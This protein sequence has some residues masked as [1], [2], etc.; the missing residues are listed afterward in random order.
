ML[1]GC[2]AMGQLG[3][4]HSLVQ[5]PRFEQADGR[6]AEIK[7]SQP[8]LSQPLGA[9]SVRVWTSVTNPNPFGFTIRRLATTLMLDGRRAATSDFPLGLSL[10][11]RQETVIPLDLVLDF[12]DIPGLAAVVRRA[13]GGQQVGYLLEGTIGIDAGAF[14]QPTFGPLTLVTG[15]LGSPRSASGAGSEDRTYTSLRL[16]FRGLEGN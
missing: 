8:S 9:A 2:A 5:P 14:G 7:L 15:E 10:N 12:V 16:F 6:P 13:A 1:A 11:A 3:A 4:I